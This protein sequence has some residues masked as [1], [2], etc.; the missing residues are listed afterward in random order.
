[1]ILPLKRYVDFR[2]RSRRKEFWMWLL[3]VVIVEIVLMVLDGALGLG[4]RGVTGST[5]NGAGRVGA[6]AH[7][8]GGVLSGLFA[9]AVLIP[10]LAVQV[11]R[12]H[13]LDRTGWWIVLPAFLYILGM[14]LLFAGAAGGGGALGIVGGI[15]MF[16]GFIAA[17]VLLVWFCL[18]GTDGPNRFGGDPLDPLGLAEL[19]EVYN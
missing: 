10:N 6:F 17:I 13:D 9:L 2:G 15:L 4:G 19:E 8:S 16:G 3:F 18:P 1:M 12:L 11:R 7:A 14:I 5:V